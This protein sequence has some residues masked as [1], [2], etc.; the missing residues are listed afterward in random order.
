MA[1]LGRAPTWKSLPPEVWRHRLLL[2]SVLL[3]EAIRILDPCGRPAWL[4]CLLVLYS[5][6]LQK[7]S[8]EPCAVNYPSNVP[9]WGS[10]FMHYGGYL[11]IWRAHWE[12]IGLFCGDFPPL[13]FLCSLSETPSNQTLFFEFLL[14]F[15]SYFSLFSL[16]NLLMFI[17]IF[18][19]WVFNIYF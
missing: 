8:F 10:I 9:W 13:H 18:F 3:S 6:S 5:E 16:K 2:L 17:F 11:E 14:Y 12:F 7:L 15:L 1:C 4:S 19:Y